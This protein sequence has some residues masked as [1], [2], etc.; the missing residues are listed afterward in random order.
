MIRLGLCAVLALLALPAL[1]GEVLVLTTVTRMDPSPALA[2]TAVELQNRGPNPIACQ[3]RTS[4]GLTTGT[5]RQILTGETWSFPAGQ[6]TQIFCVA[7]GA[8]QVTGAAT[9]VTEA[10]K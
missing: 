2:R 3:L 7:S 5:G 4:A 1:A 6:G 9:I 8:N 10:T